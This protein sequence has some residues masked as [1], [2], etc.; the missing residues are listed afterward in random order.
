[1]TPQE[2]EVAVTL[3]LML[4]DGSKLEDNLDTSEFTRKWIFHV[5]GQIKLELKHNKEV[6]GLKDRLL[7]ER[8][9]TRLCD[10]YNQTIARLKEVAQWTKNTG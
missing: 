10:C 2:E 4:P 6:F 1:M 5:I 3:Q 7:Y 8:S 9:A